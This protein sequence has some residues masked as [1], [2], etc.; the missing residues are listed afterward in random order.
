MKTEI[1]EI[2]K[3][4]ESDCR[5]QKHQSDDFHY[6]IIKKD[7]SMEYRSH[8][9]YVVSSANTIVAIN[10]YGESAVAYYTGNS[11][12]CYNCHSICLTDDGDSE[13]F[14][15][16]GWKCTIAGSS[17]FWNEG[18][19]YYLT[20][21]KNENK[22]QLLFPDFESIVKNWDVVKKFMLAEGPK[23]L[24]L[25]LKEYFDNKTI[26]QQ[27]GDSYRFKRVYH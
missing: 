8:I 21:S 26:I 27:N 22:Y 17:F 7:G 2:A 4:Y 13:Y 16:D 6:I 5:S 25:L 11:Y 9:P 20:M 10:E 1:L 19:W 15:V 3:Q 24:E 14:E 12:T 18:T 23:H